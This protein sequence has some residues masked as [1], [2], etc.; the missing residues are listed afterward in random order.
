MNYKEDLIGSIPIRVQITPQ[1]WLRYARSSGNQKVQIEYLK[2]AIA[3]NREDS[4]V[5]RML[6]SIYLNAGM[7]REAIAKIVGGENLR[8]AEM[9]AVMTEVMEGEAT[10]A[11]IAAFMTA[12]RIKGETVEEVTGAARIISQCLQIGGVAKIGQ[13]QKSLRQVLRQHFGHMHACCNEY[14]GRTQK[15]RAILLL[16]RRIHYDQRPVAEGCAE[17]A[18]EARIGGGR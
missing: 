12:L 4:G 18:A 14:F 16:R 5:R 9:L 3:M 13:Q 8:E 10:P 11:Q 15:R 7:I 2:R 6:A 1:D 17:I